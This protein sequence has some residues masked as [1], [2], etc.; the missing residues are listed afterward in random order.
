MTTRVLRGKLFSVRTPLAAGLVA[1]LVLA[2]P[3][4]SRA[5][6]DAAYRLVDAS[7][8][9]LGVPYQEFPQGEGPDGLYD[10]DPLMRTDRVDCVTFV[11]LSL[12]KAL[13]GDGAGL[14]A[15]LLRIRYR[16]G[17]VSYQ[18]RNHFT[19][20]DWLP[21]NRAAGFIRD[22][23]A[24]V[25]RGRER[26]ASKTVRK[27]AWY[28]AKTEG[29]LK[30][31]RV[32][33]LSA[34]E[35]AAL[36]AQWRELGAKM[37]DQTVTLPYVPTADLA[38]VAPSI[39]SGTIASLVRADQTDKPTMISHLGI[40]IQRDGRTWFRHAAFNDKVIDVEIPA[41]FSKYA[42]SSWPLLGLNLAA[43]VDAAPGQ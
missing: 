39:P 6:G 43:P 26:M 41:Y 27:R 31:P 29:D 37:P 7:G 11:E 20:S 23:T 19:E 2:A 32:E 8:S 28:A 25:A 4:P 33:R 40:V 14:Q 15:Q 30:G 18:T 16:G 10:S 36:V 5:G 9:F 3:A 17:V 21:N 1:L 38:A 13:A 35:K 34:P 42:R 22:I 24:E 12:A